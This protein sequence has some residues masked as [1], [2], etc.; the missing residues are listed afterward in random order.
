MSSRRARPILVTGS[1]RSGSTWVGK[2]IASHPRV[3][4][5]E[6]PFNAHVRA[7]CPVRHM[8]HLVTE[9]DEAAF[10]AYV[11]GVLR[12]R[13]PWGESLRGGPAARWLADAAF[14]TLLGLWRRLRGARPLLKDPIALFSAE[15]LA[16][17]FGMDVVVLIRHPAAFASSLKR[18]G[19]TFPFPDLLAQS[20]L[21]KG[22]LAPF[23]DDIRRVYA[24]PEDV[25][26]H[27]V[28]I[29]RILHYTILKYRLRHPEWVFV[30][31]EDLSLRPAEEFRALF[32]RLGLDFREDV[33]RTVEAF[34]SRGNASEAPEGAV[35]ELRRDSR[36]NVWNWAHRL[37]PAEVARVRAG[38]ED[39][40]RH[41][42]P[43]PGW[44]TTQGRQRRSA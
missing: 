11:G 30:R 15:W 26:D 8:W 13:H 36:A 27:A 2:M 24:A 23:E 3:A 33:R 4:Y 20:R 41:F 29:W 5:V 38:T 42:Y 12:F 10:R 32:D 14:G 35:H 21:L 6:E 18:L 17:T 44:W 22:P 34:T 16:E 40:A 37:S 25:I 28:L 9:E 7:E 19:W 31:H 43:E 1:H 39:L